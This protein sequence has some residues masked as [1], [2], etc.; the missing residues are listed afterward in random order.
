LLG[1][2]LPKIHSG[3]APDRLSTGSQNRAGADLIFANE[4]ERRP[5]ILIFQLL[6]WSK[7]HAHQ[8]IL[9]SHQIRPGGHAR[10]GGC[11]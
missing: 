5:D 4:T 3:A 2:L 9:A 1:F 8:A 10:H 6:S 11:L 7:P